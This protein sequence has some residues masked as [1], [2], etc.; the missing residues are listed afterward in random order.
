M[1]SWLS[2]T[3]LRVHLRNKSTIF[4]RFLYSEFN[5]LKK[6][7]AYILKF[8]THTLTQTNFLQAGIALHIM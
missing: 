3:N 1:L 4:R 7:P 6:N 2:F 8:L 5:L